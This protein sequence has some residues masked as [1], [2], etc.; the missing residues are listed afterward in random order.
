MV[1]DPTF[2]VYR[3]STYGPVFGIGDI[4]I[5]SDAYLGGHRS[6]ANFGTSYSLPS[7]IKD[8]RTILAGTFNFTP[9]DWEVLYLA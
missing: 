5:S 8:P 1:K 9:D 7:G 6:Y 2:A 4:Y 3:H